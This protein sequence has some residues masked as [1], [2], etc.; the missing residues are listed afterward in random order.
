[1]AHGFMMGEYRRSVDPNCIAGIAFGGIY[2]EALHI[3]EDGKNR[4]KIVES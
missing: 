2:L 1:M 4:A 3:S